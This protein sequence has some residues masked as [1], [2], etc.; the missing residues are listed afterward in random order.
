MRALASRAVARAT[1]RRL[2]TKVVPTLSTRVCGLELPSCVFNSSN[3][4]TTELADLQA[5]VASAAGAV[6]SRTACPGFVHDDA[7]MKWKAPDGANTINCLGYS[8]NTFEYY[9]SALPTALAGSRKPAWFSISGY[10]EQVAEMIEKAGA[11]ASEIPGGLAVEINLSC[12]NIPGKPPTAYD[13]DGMSDYLAT[14]FRGGTAAGVAVGVKTA[15]YFYEQQFEGAAAVL[16][17][18]PHVAFV[19]CINTVGNG[20]LIDLDSEAPVLAPGSYGGL[21]G[22]AVQAIALGNVRKL[23][24]KLRPSIAVI[25]CGGVNSGEAAFKHLLCGAEA[26]MVASALLNEGPDVFARIEGELKAIMEAKG[27]AKISDFQ[28]KLRDGP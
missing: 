25:G 23:R 5:I 21:G 18:C 4:Y 12:P 7:T 22:P 27:Y 11:L 3:P 24:S 1:T 14:V 6:A 19:T 15:P 16:N 2:S 26:V 28:G 9:C 20:L 17:N 13:F 10:A 8:P